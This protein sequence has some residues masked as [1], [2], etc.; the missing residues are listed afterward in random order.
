MDI[1]KNIFW[2]AIF[3]GALAG[4]AINFLLNLLTLAVGISVF[5]LNS[6]GT[7][8]FSLLGFVVFSGIAIF[9]MF[10]TG[11]IAGRLSPA[12]LK[13]I[14]G[15]LIGFIAWS[16]LLIITIV[17]LTNMIQFI[18]FHSNFTSNPNMVAIKIANNL[19]MMT[20]TANGSKLNPLDINIEK[21]TKVITLNAYVTF[22]LFFFGAISSCIGGYLG[23]RGKA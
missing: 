15:A 8:T 7:A 20:E 10:T 12:V 5:S 13:R 4:F 2:S 16:L 9:T 1:Q 22:T 6:T 23:Y 11:W 14:W 19:P 3:S 21:T 18:A 17:I